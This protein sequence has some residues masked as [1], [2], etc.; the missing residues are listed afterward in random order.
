MSKRKGQSQEYGLIALRK[1]SYKSYTL[2]DAKLVVTAE[3]SGLCGEDP[4]KKG[5]QSKGLAD[6]SAGQP[7]RAPDWGGGQI[8]K[9]GGA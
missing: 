7:A 4:E 9:V 5:Q 1:I 8:R 2:L 6:P 3:R